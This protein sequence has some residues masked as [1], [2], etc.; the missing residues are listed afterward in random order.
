[1]LIRDD[2]KLSD[3]KHDI[4][5]SCVLHQ[6]KLSFKKKKLYYWHEWNGNF[7]EIESFKKEKENPLCINCNGLNNITNSQSI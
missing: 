7:T 2:D 1:M 5:V 3:F 4:N 6:D